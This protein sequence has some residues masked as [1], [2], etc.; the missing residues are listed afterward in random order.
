MSDGADHQPNR[1]DPVLGQRIATALVGAVVVVVGVFALPLGGVAAVLAAVA[2]LGAWEWGRLAGLAEAVP[3]LGYI[4]V[5]AA[6]SAGVWALM[7]A[8]AR[9]LAIALAL[10]WWCGV[11]AWLLCGGGPQPPGRAVRWGWLLAGALLFPSLVAAGAALAEPNALG[12]WLLLYALCLVWIADIGAYFA[13]RAF[14]R[15][16]LAPRVSAG[17][18]RE[19]VIGALLAVAVLAGL[20]GLVLG[21]SVLAWLGWVVVALLAT[22]LSVV[23]DLFESVV[24][25][26]AGAKDSG[27]LL[28]GHGG[29][30]DRIDSLIAA[31]PVLALGVSALGLL[32]A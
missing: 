2:A 9:D 21:G 27:H 1:I 20:S 28:P 29:V 32:E 3:R 8:S 23:G 5:V 4:A 12:R 26:E 10:V 19:G 15:K 18:T 16:P 6:A 30:L 24:K 7:G 22:L 17:K 31:L 25:R 13:G 11:A 14:G